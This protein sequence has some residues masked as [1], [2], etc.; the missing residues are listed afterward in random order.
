MYSGANAEN[1]SPT[2]KFLYGHHI[3]ASSQKDK[4]N[5]IKK[6]K[7]KTYLSNPIPVMHNTSN[8]NERKALQEKM[9]LFHL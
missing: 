6:Q 7:R 9:K 4:E 5:T 3:C 8:K 2:S 1:P